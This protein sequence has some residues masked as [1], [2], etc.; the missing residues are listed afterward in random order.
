MQQQYSVGMSDYPFVQVFPETTDCI[1][2]IVKEQEHDK[3]QHDTVGKVTRL[4]IKLI[5]HLT[6]NGCQ[7][8]GAIKLYLD[9]I[10]KTL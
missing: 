2:S 5:S 3:L 8:C 10:D 4:K 1:T 9:I 6:D 7:V